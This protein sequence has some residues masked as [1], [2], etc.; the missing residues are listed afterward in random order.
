MF[1]RSWKI[2]RWRRRLAYNHNQ[3]TGKC[4]REDGTA[5]QSELSIHRK[6]KN[7]FENLEGELRKESFHEIYKNWLNIECINDEFY[8]VAVDIIKEYKE[9]LAPSFFFLDPFGFGGIPFEII[10]EILAIRKTEVFISFMIRDV[11]RFIDSSHHR[12]SIE[13]LYGVEDV[14]SELSYD[15]PLFP[16]DQAL[17]KFYR[18]RLHN[19]AKVE[20]TL[21]FKVSADDRL[22]TT[23]Y[24]IHCT[25]YPLGCEI[26]KEIMYKAGT[27][28]RFGYLGPAE[29]Q[30][31]LHQFDNKGLKD[32]LLNRFEG[33]SISYK[34]LRHRTLMDTEAI[35]ANYRTALLE[36]EGDS[37]VL[38][39]GKG[40]RG[41]LPDDAIVKFL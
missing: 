2:S 30:M 14:L 34:D 9:N 24:L 35:K 38:I 36:L 26:M 8:N 13:E 39:E 40:P 15:Y 20:F 32:L 17:L 41:G 3:L 1:C 10:K 29:G 21:P 11:N 18:D 28:G 5:K 25:N 23:Y 19:D 4:S 33:E 31:S 12:R 16:R 6:N 27:E 22:L 7:N 37:K